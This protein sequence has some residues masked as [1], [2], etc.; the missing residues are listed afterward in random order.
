MF[1][2]PDTII[3]VV[4]ARQR[5]KRTGAAYAAPVR[6]LSIIQR[7]LGYGYHFLRCYPM[8]VVRKGWQRHFTN[9]LL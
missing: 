5:S 4:A 9:D 1:H 8:R 6:L 2:S 3:L 7:V